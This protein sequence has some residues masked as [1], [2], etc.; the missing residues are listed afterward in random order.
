MRTTDS[1][2]PTPRWKQSLVW[3]EHRTGVPGAVQ[4]CAAEQAGGGFRW[5]SLWLSLIA[6][7]AVLQAVTGF[8]L[9]V[10]YSPSAQTAWESVYYLQTEVTGGWLLRG[11]HHWTAQVLVA[12]IGLYVIQM[13]V[14]GVYRAPREF[15]FWTALCLGLLA[16]ALCLTGDLLCWD[17]NGYASTKT[18]VNFLM[19][20]P[21][22]GEPMFRWA[23]PRLDIWP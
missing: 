4:A 19:L 2:S 9:W 6:C 8:F 16:L 12:L 1:Q 22:I 17:Q 3:L 11:M 21:W 13:I 14:R 23:A 20:L 15:V 10:Y 5:W 7:A 18:R